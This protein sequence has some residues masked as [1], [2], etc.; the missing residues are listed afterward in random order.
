MNNYDIRGKLTF[1][2]IN[3]V[4]VANCGGDV[5]VKNKDIEKLTDGFV[6]GRS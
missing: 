6:W 2:N 4:C 1:E 5:E 3:G